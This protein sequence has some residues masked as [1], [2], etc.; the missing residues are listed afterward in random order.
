MDGLNN[1]GEM[2]VC[3]M[4]CH[5]DVS[6]GSILIVTNAHLTTCKP[7]SLHKGCFNCF[8]ML[9]SAVHKT[10][11]FIDGIEARTILHHVSNVLVMC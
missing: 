7:S 9:P 10:K 5:G 11:Y 4:A 1:S 3:V 8:R 2:L 6:A